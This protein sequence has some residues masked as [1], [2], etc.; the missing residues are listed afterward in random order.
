[1]ELIIRFL[2]LC[3]AVSLFV[4]QAGAVYDIDPVK[5][6]SGVVG[7][8]QAW[9]IYFYSKQCLSCVKL[10]P[11]WQELEN[12]FSPMIYSGRVNVDDKV[13]NKIARDIGVLSQGLPNIRVF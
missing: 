8:Y 3:V 7:S 2:L 10:D 12:E 4:H 6:E 13:G 11:V 5:F 1:M 9:I